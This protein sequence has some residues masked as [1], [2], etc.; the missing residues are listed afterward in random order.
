MKSIYKYIVCVCAAFSVA[1][2][3]YLD[4]VP[5]NVA[6][7]DHAFADRNT[8][9]QYL[10]TCYYRMPRNAGGSWGYNPALFGA[11]E[12]V[13]NKDNVGFQEMQ[14]A[15]G[16][17]T[18]ASPQINYWNSG[19][20]LYAAIRDCNTFMERIGGVMDLNQY[21]KDRMVAEV[22]LI[23]AWCHFYLLRYYGPIC[24][25]RENTEVN[26][27]TTGVRVYREKV[28]DCFQYI[29]DLLDEAIEGDNLPL[30]IENRATE[31]GRFTR[32]AAY[33]IKAKVLL[34][35]A[36]PLFNGNTDYNSFL[37][38]NGEPFFN[39]TYDATRWTTAAEA[40]KEAMAVCESA[41]IRLYQP[42]DLVW[43]S[44]LSDETRLVQTLRGA[45]SDR[46][47]VELIWGNSS[48]AVM[49]NTIQSNA[50]PVLEETPRFP[51]DTKISVPLATVDVFYSKNGVP[52]NEDKDYDYANRYDVRQGDEAHK[53]Y[54]KQGESTAAVNFDR[55]PRFYSTLGFDRGLWYGNH[56]KNT[57]ENNADALYPKNRFGEGAS[58]QYGTNYN[59][60]GY[61]PKKLVSINTTFTTPDAVTYEVFP[62]P[63]MRY[64]DLLLMCAEAVNEAEGP[65]AAALYIDMVR[66]RAG[67]E[68][69]VESWKQHS[70]N[71]NKPSTK[72]GMREI[73]QRERN[74]EFACESQYFWDSRRWKTALKEQNRPIQGW[75]IWAME[76]MD[77]YTV[78]TLYT[79]S[80]SYKN[81]FAPIPE[82]DIIKNPML[83]QNPGY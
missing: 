1:S 15:L 40:C 4:V 54:I 67:L 45:V 20:S 21:E 69:V 25:L 51:V 10:A 39:Q 56:Y 66:E 77:Y 43:Y 76:L 49:G 68:G 3:D 65:E 29:I 75:N 52:I 19:G 78:T 60:S 11:M 38:H 70:I 7:L 50:L 64:A 2:C 71:P 32:A 58:I 23:K 6:T 72:E 61:W 16:N 82:S 28:D 81:Y 46:W 44:P 74:I 63:E 5:D 42:S 9:E 22:K 37:D 36:S 8:A 13:M 55:E 73:I 41:G 48:A 31:L 57:P 12:M 79:Q 26:E 17:N 80:F 33:A 53:Y 62:F 18:P 59:C 27:S 83:V 14:I 35:W 30:Q 47:N 34:Y 24:P